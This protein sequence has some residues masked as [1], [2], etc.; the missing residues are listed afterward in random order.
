M[1]NVQMFQIEKP[2]PPSIVAELA[3]LVEKA[4]GFQ[5]V[6]V[7]SDRIA[8]ELGARCRRGKKAIEEHFAKAKK[9]AAQAHKSIVASVAGLCGPIDEASRC[10]FSASD[11][12]QENERRKAAEEQRKLQAIAQKREDERQLMDAIE[13]EGRG[14]TQERDAIMEETPAPPVVVVAPAVAK[15]KGVSRREN[16]SAGI[17]DVRKCLRFLLDNEEWLPLLE[18]CIPVLETGLR[19]LAVAQRDALR[20]P[21]VRAVSQ[22]VRSTRVS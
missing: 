12:Y 1:S 15:V 5:V 4:R 8:Q 20:I 21:G 17:E 7:D 19:P 13:A 18:K 3:P 10:Y 11:V 9:D 16:W 6:D 22:S 14:D 2:A